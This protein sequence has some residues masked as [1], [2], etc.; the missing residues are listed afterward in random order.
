MIQHLLRA[1]LVTILSLAL[2][3]CGQQ[4]EQSFTLLASTVH[5]FME[6]QVTA[7]GR[8]MGINVQMTYQPSPDIAN[9]LQKG[10]ASGF[11]AVW[12]ASS[13]WIIL[14]DTQGVVRHSR[15]IMRSPLV[16]VLKQPVARQL[17]WRGEA[18]AM[19]DIVAAAERGQLRLAVTSPT[20][21]SLGAAAY[22]SYLTAL[23]GNP[24][25]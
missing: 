6:P 23:A 21:G 8:W 25:V 9:G 5:K 4:D 1:L 14:G 10:K 16:V 15:S 12:P 11:D 22:L 17:G 24:Q 19:R 7:V 2:F 18:I 3:G 20:R 13:L